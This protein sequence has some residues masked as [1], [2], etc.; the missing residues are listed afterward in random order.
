MTEDRKKVSTEQLQLLVEEIEKD[1]TLLS[2]RPSGRA[3]AKQEYIEK[4]KKLAKKLNTVE[5]GTLK[6]VS[7]WQQSLRDWKSNTKR[8][9]AKIRKD[10]S[11][12]N[13]V[14]QELTSLEV[15]L[16]N[17]YD[18]NPTIVKSDGIDISSII[19]VDPLP[20]NSDD[21]TGDGFLLNNEVHSAHIP[22]EYTSYKCIVNT[23][24]NVIEDKQKLTNFEELR[25]SSKDIL[26][27]LTD[28]EASRQEI[29]KCHNEHLKELITVLKEQTVMALRQSKAMEAQ[30]KAVLKLLEKTE[31]HE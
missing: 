10:K 1:S 28:L 24:K 8:K 26:T 14:N 27:R 16:L 4:W 9:A 2:G 30:T 12:Q 13:D 11:Y 17:L 5:N 19:E 31:K 21:D 29:D 7:K 22:I 15:R 6:N 18:E 20:N 23:G 3:P 25:N